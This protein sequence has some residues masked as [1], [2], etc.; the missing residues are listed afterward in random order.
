GGARS[1]EWLV[2]RGAVGYPQGGPFAPVVDVE[3]G[4]RMFRFPALV[5]HTEVDGDPV[6]P[7]V[8]SR[9]ALEAVEVL[10]GRR[11]G[12]LH[13]VQSILPIAEHAERQRGDLALV[14]LHQLTEGLRIA[15]P[16]SLDELPVARSHALLP[17]KTGART[18]Y[19]RPGAP[20]R[21]R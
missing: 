17:S 4:Q 10:V 13:D 14:A 18:S 12:F 21:H 15:R 3:G 1:L 9:V 7:G 6:H 2:G 16:R 11:E 19:S 8:E 5:V 20:G